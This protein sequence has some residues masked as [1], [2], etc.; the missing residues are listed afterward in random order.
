MFKK[1]MVAVA[2]IG[3]I[4]PTTSCAVPAPHITRQ[5]VKELH[6][7]KPPTEETFTVVNNK[8]VQTGIIQIQGKIDDSTVANVHNAFVYYKAHNIK[9]VG[10][11]L[12]SLGGRVDA[13]S[14]VSLEMIDAQENG[15]LVGTMVGHQE[16][17]A[18]MCT[19]VFAMGKIR[20]AANDSVFVFHSPYCTLTF[21]QWLN[22]WMHAITDDSRNS[23]RETMMAM[24][25]SADPIWTDSTLKSY[26]YDDS[27]KELVLTGLGITKQ[28]STYI[29]N[30]Y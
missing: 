2:A 19:A 6:I 28:S 25:A 22:P 24:Y 21:M 7:K 3:L 18:S 26:I 30:S 27:E 29:T 9:V 4:F 17:C 15:V 13:G 14:K 20:M 12:N 10:I 5:Q 16:I 8:G 1:L 23:A 11:H